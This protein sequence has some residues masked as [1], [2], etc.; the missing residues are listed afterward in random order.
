MKNASSFGF[1]PQNDGIANARS[2]NA[3]VAEA[4]EVVVSV[5]GIYEIADTVYLHSH[6]HLH[7]E[8]G[9]TLKR[10]ENPDGQNG[11][12]FINVGAFTGVRDTDIRLTG[13]HLLTNGTESTPAEC[14]GTKTVTGLRAH[15]AFLHVENV[16][17]SDMELTDLSPKDYAVQISDFK[18][19]TVER[20]HLEGLKDGIHFGNGSD[21]VVRD[22]RFR[23]AD[24]AIALNCSDYSVSNPSLG[25]LENGL[26]EN[27]TDLKGS[28]TNACF[29]R[30]L[31]GGWTAWKK[32]MTVYHSD[33]VIHEG[34]LYRVC[35]QPDNT[36]YIS[37][38]PPTHEKGFAEYDGIRWVRT[39]NACAA[40]KLPLSASCRNIVLR[41]INIQQPR[42]TQILIYASYDEYLRSYHPGYAMPA[43]SNIVLENVQVQCKTEHLIRIRTKTEPIIL[44]NCILNGSDIIQQQNEQMEPYAP[45]P[46]IIQ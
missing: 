45:T 16:Y 7:F 12:A 23:T 25:D 42:D 13:L 22:C 36:A 27:C 14:G 35:M 15:V 5:P 6:T 46:I 9:V 21:F 20:C 29:L 44:R 18:N 19:A 17:V 24:D 41:N 40:D 33:A 31:V 28:P 26:I 10:V 43:V 32:G 11:N 3:A 8:K 34:K 30:I 1:L 37:C 39:N 38:T 4:G 2:L